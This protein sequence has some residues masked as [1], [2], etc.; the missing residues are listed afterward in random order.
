[1]SLCWA[2]GACGAPPVKRCSLVVVF[3]IPGLLSH[4]PWVY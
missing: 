2:G 4:M 3:A 1:V